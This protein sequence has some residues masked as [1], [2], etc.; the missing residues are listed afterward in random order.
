M[1]AHGAI[2]SVTAGLP[3]HS[4]PATDLSSETPEA[5]RREHAA[6]TWAR[7]LKPARLHGAAAT[8][9][10]GTRMRHSGSSEGRSDASQHDSQPVTK[11]DTQPGQS[12][13]PLV[14]SKTL[15]SKLQYSFEALLGMGHGVLC[16][17]L[18]C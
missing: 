17:K 8:L 7:G 3:G 2:E 13:V 14:E 4:T 15:S 6:R 10:R 18:Y 1:A 12:Q 11:H 9:H 5:A 16:D